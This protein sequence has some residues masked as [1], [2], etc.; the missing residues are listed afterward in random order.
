MKNWR[1]VVTSVT[2]GSAI[3][4][5]RLYLSVAFARENKE[6]ISIIREIMFQVEKGLHDLG[7]VRDRRR[8]LL[9]IRSKIVLR[10]TNYQYCLVTS[11][12]EGGGILR[13]LL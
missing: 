9:Y 11:V 13:S 12:T 3:S 8:V 2:E 4:A 7:H 5:V 6:I 1:T 10:G